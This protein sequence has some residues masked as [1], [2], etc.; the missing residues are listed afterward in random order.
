MIQ[1]FFLMKYPLKLKKHLRLHAKQ[2][3]ASKASLDT[4][5][6]QDVEEIIQDLN[7]A[8]GTKR[9]KFTDHDLGRLSQHNMRE[10]L[11][12]W[13][14]F[15]RGERIKDSIEYAE[16]HGKNLSTLTPC[17]KVI[18]EYERYKEYAF[19]GEQMTDEGSFDPGEIRRTQA[20]WSFDDKMKFIELLRIHKRDWKTIAGHF[21]GKSVSQC[22]NFFQNYKKKLGLEAIEA[23]SLS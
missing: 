21:E 13:E 16:H 20:I 18:N 22:K 4:M 8:L 12:N 1:S 9:L 11:G 14:D 3:R 15:S 7:E 6:S 5:I 17:T 2:Y 23:Q 10:S 19:G